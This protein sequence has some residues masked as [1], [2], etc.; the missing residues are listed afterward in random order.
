MNKKKLPYSQKTAKSLYIFQKSCNFAAFYR[1]K[2]SMQPGKIHLFI[3]FLIGMATY[4]MGQVPTDTLSVNS[5][6]LPCAEVHSDQIADSIIQDAVRM[7]GIPYKYGGRSPQGM[8]CSGFVG[9][10][11]EKYGFHLAHSAREQSLQGTAVDSTFTEL[12]KGDLVFFGGRGNTGTIGHVGIFIAPDDS[13]GES[14]S[15]IHVAV[16]GGVQISHYRET[17][18]KQRYIF[19]RRLLPAIPSSNHF[20]DAPSQGF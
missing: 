6:D 20:D 19:A 16:H 11:F 13:V 5:I 10:L 8:D 14:F 3:I 2:L 7:L 9:Y 4:A 18:Y 17:Y 1:T 12:Q 15:F